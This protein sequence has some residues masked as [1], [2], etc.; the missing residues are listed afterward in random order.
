V[1]PFTLI[2]DGAAYLSAQLLVSVVGTHVERPLRQSVIF[3]LF[4]E[5]LIVWVSEE[6]KIDAFEA[7]HTLFNI[8]SLEA[9]DA[10]CAY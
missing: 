6:L 1:T 8:Q 3:I 5:N 4:A 7:V 10:A 2:S 9:I